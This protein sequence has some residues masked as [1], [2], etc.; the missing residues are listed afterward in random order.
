MKQIDI[1][2]LAGLI[3]GEGC[4]GVRVNKHGYVSNSLQITMTRLEPLMWSKTTTGFGEI[5]YKKEKRKNRKDVYQWSVSNSE[6]IRILL[7]QL[8]PFLKVKKSEAMAFMVLSSLKRIKHN[9][10][11]VHIEAENKLANMIV[12][13]KTL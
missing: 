5:Y 13:L 7:Q 6:E 11:R 2:Y 3:D 9:G 10:K 12:N 1:A 8:I 4:I